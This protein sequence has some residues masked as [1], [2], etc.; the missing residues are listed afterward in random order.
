M[1]GTMQ[2]HLF[3]DLLPELTDEHCQMKELGQ[4]ELRADLQQIL[5]R[6]GIRIS[7][8]IKCEMAAT[9]CSYE[10]ACIKFVQACDRFAAAFHYIDYGYSIKD[11]EKNAS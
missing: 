3:N 6:S 10:E 7:S 9:D 2:S 1:Q 8:A 4:R 5:I 11:S